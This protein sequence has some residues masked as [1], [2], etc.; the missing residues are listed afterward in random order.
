MR[1]TKERLD[2]VAKMI[3]GALSGDPKAQGSIKSEI[4]KSQTQD[5]QEDMSTSDFPTALKAITTV[6]FLSQYQQIDSIWDQY[7]RPYNVNN[8]RPQ[9]F[10]S[11]IPDFSNLPATAGGVSTVLQV[12]GGVPRVPELTE[13]PSISFSAS[14][15]SFGVAK[16]GARVNFSFEMLLNDEW[17]VLES[18]PN[19]LA[20]LAKNQEDIVATEALASPSGPNTLFFNNGNLNLV[21]TTNGF[22]TNNPAL[23]YDAVVDATNVIR[24]RKYNGNP[25]IVKQFALMV[26]PALAVTAQRMLQVTQFRNVGVGSTGNETLVYESSQIADIKLIINPW[27]PIIDASGNVNKTWYLIPYQSEGVRP[28]VVFSKI[29]GREVPELRI[30]DYTGDYLGGGEIP[31]SEG[32]FLNDDIQFRVRHFVGAAGIGFETTAVSNGSGS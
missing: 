1:I 26:P 6:A 12:P 16:Y 9:A 10:Y 15:S 22:A 5:I 19:E 20:Q 3:D 25:V 29:R 14:A 17:N 18:L 27:L 21:N 30:A 24:Q 11:L 31:G 4:R 13:F 23:T 8:L 28:A 2:S 32:S 7:A